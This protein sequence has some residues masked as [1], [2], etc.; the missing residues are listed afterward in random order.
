MATEDLLYVCEHYDVN[1]EAT[2]LLNQGADINGTNVH[3]QT[4]LHL[5]CQGCLRFADEFRHCC[6]ARALILA[7]LLCDLGADVNFADNFGRTPL[8]VACHKNH[9]VV[10]LRLL[11]HHGA[12]VNRVDSLGATPLWCA[13]EDGHA[14]AARLLLARGAVLDQAQRRNAF[15]RRV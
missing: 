15:F 6:G 3:G 2:Q 9:P 1:N 5:A 11:L 14:S 10:L 12:D 8:S 7:K 13:C 4:P